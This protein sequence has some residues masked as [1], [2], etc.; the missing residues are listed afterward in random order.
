MLAMY[1]IWVAT[2]MCVQRTCYC[3]DTQL[4]TCIAPLFPQY[5]I[6]LNVYE[7]FF[8]ILILMF[9]HLFGWEMRH[10]HT[11]GSCPVVSG[12]GGGV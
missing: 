1:L 3:D 12:Q 5:Q 8:D 4:G 9:Y 11:G 7:L 10:L 6:M 2:H